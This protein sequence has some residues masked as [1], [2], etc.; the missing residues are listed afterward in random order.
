MNGEV[1]LTLQ[2]LTLNEVQVVALL[3]DAALE[4][5]NEALEVAVVQVE[6]CLQDH[7]AVRGR[8]GRATEEGESTSLSLSREYRRIRQ[9]AHLTL[10]LWRSMSRF[11]AT[12]LVLLSPC[13]VTRVTT[14]TAAGRWRAQNNLPPR[15]ASPSPLA[16]L[17]EFS[18][19]DGRGA[20]PLSMGRRAK[21]LRDQVFAKEIVACVDQM[22][23]SK[24]LVPDEEPR[25]F[26]I[27]PIDQST[28]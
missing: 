1:A 12:R 7:G 19:V 16:D 3:Q 28:R 23:Q 2:R 5:A 22:K 21:Y 26:E 9:S 10:P 15:Y 24:R 8:T 11:F 14:R 6:E 25:T 27:K 18:F 4:A 20:A 17:P 13:P